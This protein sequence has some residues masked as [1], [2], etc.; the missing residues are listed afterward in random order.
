VHLNPPPWR[1]V[2]YQSRV[3]S[4]FIMMNDE[5]AGYHDIIPAPFWRGPGLKTR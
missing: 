4:K 1:H 3:T 5:K 2:Q